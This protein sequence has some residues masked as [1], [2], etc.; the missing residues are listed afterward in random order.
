VIGLLPERYGKP[1]S[2]EDRWS[3]LSISLPRETA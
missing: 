1:A 3:S 2:C